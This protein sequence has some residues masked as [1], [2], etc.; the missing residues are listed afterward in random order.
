[1]EIH[2]PWTNRVPQLYDELYGCDIFASLPELF[3][4]LPDGKISVARYHYHDMISELFA[5]S[6]A[7]TIGKWCG[8][9]N[10][11]L[12]GHLM[13]EPSL[14]S[15][16]A[17]LGETMRSYRSFQLPGIDMLC[18]NHEFTTAKQ[19]QSATHQFGYEGV[20]S[21]LYGVTGWHCDFRT[22]K[23]QGDW[24]AALGVTVRVPHLSWY[25][26]KG[27]AK[28]DYPASIHYQSPWYKEYPVLEDHF[29]RVNT[30]M[31][32]GKPLVRVGVIHPV[33]S[34]W[35]HWGP[36][37]KTAL[38]RSS[39][40]DRF[41][42]VTEWL[43]TGSVDFDFISES[44]FP[45]LCK[46]GSAPLKVGK[47]EYDVI[48][49]PGCE[50]LRSSTYKLLNEF[51]DANG[52]L[53]IMGDCPSLCDAVV[54][55]E[56]QKLAKKATNIDYSRGSLLNA[57]EDNRVL[58]I[59]YA[60]GALAEN[61]IYQMRSD[62]SCRWLFIANA[63]EPGNKDVDEG[64]DTQIIINGEFS[65][66]KYDT[67]SGE[68]CSVPVEYRNNKTIIRERI[69]AY[70]SLLLKLTEGKSGAPAT[71]NGSA[72]EL[73]EI[74]ENLFD[75]ELSEP[76]VLLLDMAEYKLDIDKNFA[77]R[78]ELLRLDNI[79][80]RRL[81]LPE[82]GGEI[83]QPYITGKVPSEHTLTLRF[84]FESEI[85]CNGAKLALED[86]DKAKIVLNG[87]N[88]TAATDGWFTDM[89]IETVPLP[90]I[91]KGKNVLEVTIPIGPSTYTED[92]FILGAFGVKALG[93]EAKIVPLP[94]KVA[95]SDIT[96][97]G[98]PFYGGS[99]KYK[100]KAISKNGQLSIRTSYYRGALIG[101]FVDKKRCGSIIYPPY[102]LKVDGLADGEHEVELE[103]FTNRANC[104]GP[105]HNCVENYWWLGPDSWRT[106]GN[107]WSYEYMLK[108]MG[109]LSSPRIG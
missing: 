65:A 16:T 106:E 13:E 103:L 73:E 26:M 10:I 67:Q 64:K 95:F 85:S 70:D 33:E 24:Q 21:E 20:L 9:N 107:E 99:I 94:E 45:T 83:V 89:A 1:M 5:R 75:Y 30:A 3:W 57:L 47:M 7:D 102:E 98:F 60:D 12:T 14:Q 31:T 42:S 90:E 23:H 50:T 77:P 29:A 32:R 78:E 97:Q 11:A 76:N 86:A 82:N 93:K 63:Y 66:E 54:S 49:V 88:V 43:L 25:S 48:I 87:E 100:F 51:A 80:R 71:E 58:T 46:Q 53:I 55:D 18:N 68:I 27:E 74:A 28:R 40:D 17:A 81:G 38:L 62:N 44:L 34:F 59:R 96:K 72:P 91:V 92:M 41:M 52:K 101:V 19:A 104:F 15:Q 6:F 108:P 8:E 4:D 2:L 105:V 36:K 109:I 35:L 79:C 56:G 22:Y 37:D 61:F 39:L 69:Y 84:T